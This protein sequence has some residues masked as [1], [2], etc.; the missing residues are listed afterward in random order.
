MYRRGSN[1]KALY[2]NPSKGVHPTS[3]TTMYSTMNDVG[4]NSFYLLCIAVHL[5]LIFIFCGWSTCVL[6]A[7]YAVL[8]Q[9]I[10]EK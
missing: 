9:F 10:K 6:V 1:C 2:G 7:I 8:M 4:S 3:S 5:Q